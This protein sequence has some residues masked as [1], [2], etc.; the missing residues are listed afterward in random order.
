MAVESWGKECLLVRVRYEGELRARWSCEPNTAYMLL[1]RLGRAEYE[2]ESLRKRQDIV[3]SRPSGAKQARRF[4]AKPSTHLWPSLSNRSRLIPL[5]KPH[6]IIHRPPDCLVGGE[7]VSCC[8]VTAREE[9]DET[10]ARSNRGRHPV[11]DL[12]FAQSQ[13]RTV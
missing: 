10:Y 8:S 7:H 13:Y 4:R 11:E 12:A 3:S 5:R 9:K 1:S 2:R 6:L